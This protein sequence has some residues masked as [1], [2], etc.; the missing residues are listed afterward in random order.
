[1]QWQL[2]EA[3]AHFSEVVKLAR[4]EGPQV[5]TVHGAPAAVVISAEAYHTLTSKHPS[6][7]DHILSGPLWPDDL[8]ETINDRS[9]DT[10]RDN[11]F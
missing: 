4:D 5:V 10:G 11:E 7:V 6:I 9:P 8:V 1:M 2:Q 3:K